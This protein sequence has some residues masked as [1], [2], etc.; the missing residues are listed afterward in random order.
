MPTE[1][2]KVII[3]RSRGFSCKPLRNAI[4]TGRLPCSILR[5]AIPAIQDTQR[6][7]ARQVLIYT[8]A[9]LFLLL[10]AAKPRFVYFAHLV[11]TI[12]RT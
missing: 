9:S 7:E 6:A 5:E 8:D 11:D 12:E 10:I 2:L 3:C 1:R 4:A